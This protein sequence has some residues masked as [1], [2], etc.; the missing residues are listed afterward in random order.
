MFDKIGG[1]NEKDLTVSFN[2]VDL[3]LRV[4]EAG[5]RIVWT[6]YAELYHHESVSRGPDT[7]PDN[8][9]RSKSEV[10]YMLGRWDHILD[11]D[12]Y[13]NPNLRLDGP[14]FDLAFPPRMEMPWRHGTRKIIP[15]RAAPPRCECAK[16]R[17]ATGVASRKPF[18]FRLVYVSG[19]PEIPGHQYRVI[20]PM[21]AAAGL[22]AET[23]WMQ[24][25]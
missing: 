23:A 5:Y 24:D 10:A 2:D 15:I 16:R 11:R 6:P 8:I 20:R 7:D 25:R 1:F 14:A 22:G 4:R 13:Y 21:A 12:P 9:E 3:C 18:A 17:P 19:E